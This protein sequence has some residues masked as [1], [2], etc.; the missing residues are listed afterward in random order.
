MDSL[1]S[2]ENCWNMQGIMQVIY[3]TIMIHNIRG[4]NHLENKFRSPAI[5]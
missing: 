4:E 5:K 2:Y 3:F 1:F